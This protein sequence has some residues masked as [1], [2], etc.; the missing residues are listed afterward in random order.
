MQNPCKILEEFL[1]SD[2]RGSGFYTITCAPGPGPSHC[3]FS[4][5]FWVLAPPVLYACALQSLTLLVSLYSRVVS[6]QGLII[7]SDNVMKATAQNNVYLHTTLHVNHFKGL[8]SSVEL[9]PCIP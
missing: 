5:S 4:A 6:F 9:W 7:P 3:S 1:D 2:E 8:K